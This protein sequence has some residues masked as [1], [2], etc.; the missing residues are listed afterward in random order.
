MPKG[1]EPRGTQNRSQGPA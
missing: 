1:A